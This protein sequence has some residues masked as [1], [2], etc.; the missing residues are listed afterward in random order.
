MSIVQS[1][2]VSHLEGAIDGSHLEPNVVQT[3]HEGRPIWV[4]YDLQGIGQAMD[5]SDLIG[6]PSNLWRYKEL[7]P[8]YDESKIVSFGE[9]MSP[10]LKSPRLGAALG[11]DDLWVKDESQLPT[12]SFKSR[13]MAMAV[14]MANH[15]GIESVALPTAGNAGGAAAAYAARAGMSCY[16]FMP[17]DTP[18]INQ[19]EACL[20]Y[21]SPSPRDA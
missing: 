4:R 16:V 18:I 14:T 11:L 5:R 8:V 20:L 2:F 6:R 13:G 19:Y 12:G 3:L 7:L 15:F 17:E 10:L 21:T 9:G 1:S